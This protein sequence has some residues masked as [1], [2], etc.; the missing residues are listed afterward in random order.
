[1]K[2]VIVTGAAGGMGREITHSLVLKGYNVIPCARKETVDFTD[3]LNNL[4]SE[5]SSRICPVYFDLAIPESIMDGIKQIKNLNVPIDA[6][7]NNAGMIHNALFMMTSIETMRQV[8]Q[9]NFFGPIQFTQFVVKL[10]IRNKS[11]EKNIINIASTA[12]L[13]ANPG[14]LTYGSSK[15]A[16]IIATKTLAQELSN[17][18]IRVNAIAPSM[19]RTPMLEKDMSPAVRKIEIEKKCIRRIGEPI[20]IANAVCFL[21]SNES[22]YITGQV[23]RVDGGVF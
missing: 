8:F 23:L 1:M 12:G 20:D 11:T 10:M 5:C 9:V 21:L 14:K 22:S 6:L 13:D 19:T 3:F 16:V 17:F 2:N 4:S 7:I 18:N 15:S